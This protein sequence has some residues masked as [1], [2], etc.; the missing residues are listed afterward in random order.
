MIEPCRVRSQGILKIALLAMMFLAPA[1]L[2]AQDTS[3]YVLRENFKREI[4]IEGK[5]YRVY[6]NWVTFG[7]GAGYHSENPRTQFVLGMNFQFHI[8]KYYFNFGG[9]MSGD[10]FGVWNNYG[11]HMGF[12]PFRKENE[13]RNMAAMIGVNYTLGY[14]Y[15]YA[16]HYSSQRWDRVGL[17]AEFQYTMKLQYAVGIG[18]TFFV[19]WNPKRV[20]AGIRLEGYLSGAYRGYAKG[21]GPPK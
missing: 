12:V 14:D 21:Y 10:E 1:F 20:L 2:R 16:G 8:K 6:N 18:P 4:I 5:R 11:A 3:T 13:Q 19:D 7:A 15:V 17:Y 9:L